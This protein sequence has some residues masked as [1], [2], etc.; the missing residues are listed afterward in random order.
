MQRVIEIF[1]LYFI[2]GRVF[3]MKKFG[4]IITIT[5]SLP[6]QLQAFHA[7]PI[8]TSRQSD[9]ISSRNWCLK[10]EHTRS[11]FLEN[12]FQSTCSI[13]VLGIPFTASADQDFT[14]QACGTAEKSQNCVS[15]SSVKNL[16]KYSPPWTYQCSPDEAFARLKGVIASEPELSIIELEK[17][18]RYIKVS[19]PRGLA[20]DEIEFVVRGN[21]DNVVTF[22]SQEINGPGVSDFGAMRSRLDSL[23]KKSGVF[24]I[25]GAG[26]TADSYEMPISNRGALGQLKAFY[27]LQS[28]KGFESVFEDDED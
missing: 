13:L 24:D 14:I 6:S 18:A 5:W 1:V 22:R 10:A 25:M 19:A 16:D 27:G 3:N 21:G 4:L 26:M 17:S 7:I 8:R 9:R 15:T 12:L 11:N 20:S 23:R 28:G 2:H